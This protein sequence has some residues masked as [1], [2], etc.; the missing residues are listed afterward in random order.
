MQSLFT[1]TT[2]TIA[3]L[4]TLLATTFFYCY[5]DT[6]FPLT[7]ADITTTTLTKLLQGKTIW[8]TGASSGIGKSL[9]EIM[10]NPK[11]GVK[12]LIL[13]ARR[14]KELHQIKQALLEK[15]PIL[16]IYIVPLDLSNLVSLPGKVKQAREVAG[17]PID[18][19]IN[20]GGIS[21][22][23][24]AENTS[25]EVDEMLMKV[26]FLS[27]VQ[28]IKSLLPEWIA[29]SNPNHPRKIINI[30]SLAGKLGSPLRTA[31][32]AS[33]FAMIGHFDCLRHEVLKY[34]ID[35][36]NI[37]PGSVQTD[38][39][40]NALSG[41]VETNFAGNDPNIEN[42]MSVE[43][44]A[45]LILVASQANLYEAWLFGSRKEQIGAYLSQYMPGLFQSFLLKGNTKLRHDAEML[46]KNKSS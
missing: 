19:V 41:N 20:N 33:K 6:D 17:N 21:Q 23:S 13:S 32:S 26:N 24:F 43:R 11:Y 30:V 14:E 45:R 27:A 5:S 31:Y 46:L 12:T 25:F 4:T 10:S 44:C 38:V 8:C 2:T 37:C 1:I 16:N 34:H 35:I 40:R 18:I 28:I 3:L 7:F 39:A 15:N 9:V 22:R 42:G 29:T 36:T